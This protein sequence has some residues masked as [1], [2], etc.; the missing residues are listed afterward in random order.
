MSGSP[1]VRVLAV[2]SAGGHW[3]QLLRLRP[4]F[5]GCDVTFLTTDKGD[6]NAAGEGARVLRVNDA[7]RW[8]KF[9]VLRMAARVLFAVLRVRPD[10]IVS[11]GAAPG[12][13][14]LRFG[15]WVGAR[16]VWLDSIANAD[17]LSMTGR[18]VR[19]YADLWL[20]QWEHLAA[21]EGPEFAGAVL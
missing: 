10:V 5:D 16:T 15:R 4:A 14:A 1:P 6:G 13:F 12:Y 3:T 9:G 11:T 19:P 8:N 18:M 20:T 21:P 17:E 2:A 7:S